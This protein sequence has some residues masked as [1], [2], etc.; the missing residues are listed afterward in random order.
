MLALVAQLLAGG[1]TL[2]AR[3]ESLLAQGKL[4]EAR[5]I[6]E[7]LVRAHPH[8]A[9]PHLL[10]GRVWYAWPVIGRYTALAQFD[11]A[12][13]VAPLD[14]E[15]L[16]WRMKVGLFLGLDEGEA[17]ARKA[18]LR[19]FELDPDYRDTWA[20][21]RSLY[22]SDDVCRRADTALARHG[23][24]PAS[25]AHRAELALRLGEWTRADSL[26]ERLRPPRT[27]VAAQLYVIRALAAFGG[28]QDAAGYAWYDSALASADRDSAG[29]L[30][31]DVEPIA[32]P[33]EVARYDSTP[34]EQRR[35]FFERF[36]SPRDPDLLTLQNE[37]IAEHY[38]RLAYVRRQFPLTHPLAWSIRSPIGRS[39]AAS[40]AR[41][42]QQDSIAA[43]L[44]PLTEPAER[45]EVS[46]RSRA[47]PGSIET[48]GSAASRA[49]L[50]PQGI[51]WLR[52]GPPEIYDGLWF[53][54]TPLGQVWL[55]VFDQGNGGVAPSSAP[56]FPPLG[57][58]SPMHQ[59][60]VV[61]RM[62]WLFQHDRTALPAPL[63]ARAWYAFFM[64][65]VPG[66]T[67]VYAK[68]IP[69]TAAAALWDDS[70][71]E[72]ARTNGVGLLSLMVPPGT[73][74]FGLDVDSAGVLGRARQ[75]LGVPAFSET[76]LALS[77]L[78]LVPG[79]SVGDQE[80][81]LAAMPADLVYPAGRPLA[82][83]AEIYGL[84]GDATGR[85][86]YRVEYTFAPLR[87]LPRRLLGGSH[88]VRLAF[89]REA[90][91]RGVMPERLVLEAGRLEPGRYRVSVAVTDLATDVK[92]TTVALDI[93]VH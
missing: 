71:A 49:G 85:A 59:R 32:S 51:V 88:E 73:Y 92:T 35:Q 70:G 84:R 34:P 43:A 39:L 26:L 31:R 22:L 42:A 33:A 69:E 27:D 3:A 44:G 25:L 8:E 11:S 15:P 46:R 66:T 54:Q 64:G 16:Y 83:Y 58:R 41:E 36:W 81:M 57:G 78:V 47:M 14:P 76:A 75:E 9:A 90:P 79:D 87:A 63:E 62:V 20:L 1:D 5:R 50:R 61:E 89:T 68:A 2:S 77:S 80:G 13:R 67:A 7:Q 52:Q 30:W 40:Y 45:A 72:A 4:P 48:L 19:L 24:A 56:D 82:A 28:G 74:R 12:A 60:L 93:A 10:L 37:R 55:A 29:A 17:I 53:Y 23:A 38:R 21:F 65:H 91:A 18:L 6:A 86:R